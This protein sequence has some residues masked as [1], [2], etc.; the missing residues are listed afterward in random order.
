[1]INYLFHHDGTVTFLDFGASQRFDEGS[2]VD[3]QAVLDEALAGYDG[4]VPFAQRRHP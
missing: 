4:Y 3:F 2:A 1:M